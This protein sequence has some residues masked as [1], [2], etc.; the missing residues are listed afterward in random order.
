MGCAHGIEHCFAA[1][2]G[3]VAGSGRGVGGAWVNGR[4][5]HFAL[6][7]HAGGKLQSKAGS[8]QHKAGTRMFKKKSFHESNIERGTKG[9][10]TNKGKA[11]IGGYKYFIFQSE[12]P[13][14]RA[15]YGK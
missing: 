3:P 10:L 7:T 11:R 5:A 6:G 13:R 14:R 15:F 2:P 4:A 8:K 9:V 1:N 12:A